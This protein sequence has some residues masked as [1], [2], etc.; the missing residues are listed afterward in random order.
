MVLRQ[1]VS[2]EGPWLNLFSF[3]SALLTSQLFLRLGLLVAVLSDSAEVDQILTHRS[4]PPNLPALTQ[5]KQRRQIVEGA[6][7]FL[8]T[9]PKW[10]QSC[11]SFF[12]M[13]LWNSQS[14]K[15][16]SKTKTPIACVTQRNV[17][18]ANQCCCKF[19]LSFFWHQTVSLTRGRWKLF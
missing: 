8:E 18:A 16:R 11:S 7:S 14:Q 5:Q 19:F 10:K 3:H 4:S 15:S 17:L 12:Q 2:D 13:R 1:R 6:I 9:L